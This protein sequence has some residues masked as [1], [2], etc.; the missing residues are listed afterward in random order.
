MFLNFINP[1]KLVVVVFVTIIMAFFLTSWMD[2]QLSR[3]GRKRKLQEQGPYALYGPKKEL[4]FKTVDSTYDF[5]ITKVT[6]GKKVTLSPGVTQQQVDGEVSFEYVVYE[7]IITRYVGPS[8]EFMQSL[9]RRPN[10]MVRVYEAPRVRHAT[11]STRYWEMSGD[12]YIDIVENNGNVLV[13][14]R[15]VVLAAQ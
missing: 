7:C 10:I 2:T 8:M 6:L 11:E 5:R 9:N 3:Q 15:G 13:H 4:M 1:R 14:E 12:W